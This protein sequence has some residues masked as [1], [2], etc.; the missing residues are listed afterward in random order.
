[1]PQGLELQQV[2]NATVTGLSIR[3][4]TT[5]SSPSSQL[6]KEMGSLGLTDPS[7][8]SSSS[9]LPAAV[10]SPRSQ[11]GRGHDRTTWTCSVLEP[12]DLAVKYKDV[13]GPQGRGCI[14]VKLDVSDVSLKMSPDVLQLV[15]MVRRGE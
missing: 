11:H 9:G 14:E 1:L 7:A 3:A 12:C 15:Y 5:L 6:R 10:P 13:T 4:I 2:C 8:S